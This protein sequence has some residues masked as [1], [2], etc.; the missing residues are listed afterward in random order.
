M[1]GSQQQRALILGSFAEDTELLNTVLELEK[2][3]KQHIL[4][5]SEGGTEVHKI[6]IALA[7]M[8]LADEL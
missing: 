3:A 2:E 4:Q 8:A 5:F 1:A 7:F 6:A